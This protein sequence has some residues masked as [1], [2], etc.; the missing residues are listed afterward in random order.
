MGGEVRRVSGSGL[1]LRP[2]VRPSLARRLSKLTKA[3]NR[4]LGLALHPK[5][6]I[7]SFKRV[8]LCILVISTILF[9]GF[10]SFYVRYI[11]LRSLLQSD[12][13]A[14]TLRDKLRLVPSI[15]YHH[16]WLNLHQA[17]SYCR[18]DTSIHSFN[19]NLQPHNPNPRH[20][21]TTQLHT[22]PLLTQI[23]GMG[24]H[25]RP[26]KHSS[27]I[28]FAFYIAR[29]DHKH[30]GLWER[31]QVLQRIHTTSQYNLPNLGPIR[32]SHLPNRSLRLAVS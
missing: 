10:F 7:T 31:I 23:L 21:T 2:S 27:F 29:L 6:H 32:P 4:E 11:H 15:N 30:T 9:C 26:N 13:D 16:K 8:K 22:T 17:S 18:L 24:I 3:S 28:Y 12:N 20:P 25:K 1:T 5:M 14:S 19:P